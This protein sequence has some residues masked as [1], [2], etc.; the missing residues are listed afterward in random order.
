MVI[1]E[2]TS[3]TKDN[4]VIYPDICRGTSM[5]IPVQLKDKDGNLVILED[6]KIYFTLKAV[7]SDYDYDDKKALI[8]KD[9]V[10]DGDYYKIILSSK[11][12]WLPVG[13]Y[14]FDIMLK[15]NHDIIKLVTC[16]TK[17]SPTPSN[18]NQSELAE[19]IYYGEL[20]SIGQYKTTPIQ[21]T[22]SGQLFL[23]GKDLPIKSTPSFLLKNLDGK[24]VLRHETSRMR[25]PLTLSLEKN[26]SKIFIFNDLTNFS[27]RDENPLGNISM[28]IN[29]ES[30][31]IWSIPLSS[32]IELIKPCQKCLSVGEEFEVPVGE[33]FLISICFEKH[34]LIIKGF[35]CGL[36]CFLMVEWF[37][38]NK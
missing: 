22:L 10:L 16:S 30:F 32:Q 17:I 11:E 26:L 14:Y 29:G 6:V 28:K 3:V 8:K 37:D 33:E 13:D 19:G 12:T 4:F 27:F 2:K 35:N 24:K 9:A 38:F 18:R 36:K 25:F 1:N 7:A 5:V 23:N 34:H 21:V 15:K 20:I 31:S